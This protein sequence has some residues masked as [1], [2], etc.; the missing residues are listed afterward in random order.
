MKMPV[1]GLIHFGVGVYGESGE[2]KQS[3]LGLGIRTRAVGRARAHV[4]GVGQDEHAVLDDGVP[5]VLVRPCLK[6]K[7]GGGMASV[8]VFSFGGSNESWHPPWKDM[9]RVNFS[10]EKKDPALRVTPC[11]TSRSNS[12]V[13]CVY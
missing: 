7:S 9:P 5:F 2:H 10:E 13:L 11:F 1:D 4:L 8:H 6:W 3:R 12:N